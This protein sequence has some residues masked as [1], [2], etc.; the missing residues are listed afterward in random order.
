MKR[1][2][3]HIKNLILKIGRIMSNQILSIESKKIPI[4]VTSVYFM[5]FAYVS[6][7]HHNYWFESD[8]IFYL[9]WGNEILRGNGENV[10]LT[11]AQAGGPIIYAYL[12]SIF[13]DGF[14]VL[15]S[16][17]LLGSTGIVFLSYFIAKNIFNSKIAIVV[18][19][20]FAFTSQLGL[21]SIL[22]FNELLVFFSIFFSLYF[23]TKKEIKPLDILIV[24]IA[25]GFAYNIRFQ[26]LIVFI[27]FFIFLLIRDKK[28]RVNSSHVIIMTVAFF[29]AAS[30]ILVYNYTT[31]GV[32]T[33]TD[34]AF[35]L[36]LG[37][38]YSTEEWKNNLM[39]MNQDNV[40]T[41]LD[42]IFLDF[43]LFMKNYFYNLF[44]K[45]PNY[46][47]HFNHI[48]N[49]SII[50]L[51]PYIGLIP[52]VIGYLHILK[53]RINKKNISI[54]FGTVFLSS[55]IVFLFGDPTI[56]FFSII[57]IPIL[58]ISIIHFKNIP[59]NFLPLVILAV[60]FSSIIA[61]VPISRS[62][63][64]FPIWSII[65]I[66]NAIF[67]VEIVPK[68]YYKLKNS[69]KRIKL[70]HGNKKIIIIPILIIL[71]I[72]FGF[73]YKLVDFWLYEQDRIE[74]NATTVT[75]EFLEIFKEKNRYERGYE[76]KIVG[77]ILAKQPNIEN[78]YIMALDGSWSYYSGGKFVFGSFSEGQAGDT[79][80]EYLARENWS[81]LEIFSSNQVNYPADRY[82]KIKPIPDYVIYQPHFTSKMEDNLT[83]YHYLSMLSDPENSKIPSN[84]E[85][86]YKSNR[87][88]TTVYKINKNN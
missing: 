59:K 45:V 3:R 81:E 15:K 4:I 83:Q 66:L 72:N 41:T 58:I 43:D 21:L 82:N 2:F 64:L 31:H 8:G 60:V 17:A 48:S 49:L 25:L 74:V 1:F 76:S 19:L 46:L 30:P 54:I 20:F 14:I 67:F 44:Y 40:N 55:G 68:I 6:F 85:L 62:Y 23:I 22:A 86:L 52:V 75:N 61:I 38:E 39:G 9:N 65:A 27:S 5:V 47:F 12:T 37:A 70:D 80:E 71:L 50:P 88:D 29:I 42:V 78:S 10:V 35:Y 53:I 26:A 32:I 18:L 51:I 87:T 16:I 69:K 84:F 34:L 7:F 57:I 11:N 33:D 13:D 63:H 79:I 28:I 24:G 36:S 56:H 73:T 77:D